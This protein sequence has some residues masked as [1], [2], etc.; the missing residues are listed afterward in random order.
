MRRYLIAAFVA[1]VVGFVGLW[2]YVVF[3][4]GGGHQQMVVPFDSRTSS[5]LAMASLQD[6]AVDLAYQL[7]LLDN[8][9]PFLFGFPA[10]AVFALWT[11]DRRRSQKQSTLAAARSGRRYDRSSCC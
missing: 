5:P 10:I 9:L 7:D 1:E 11:I 6:Q 4:Y 8:I 3:L 2:T